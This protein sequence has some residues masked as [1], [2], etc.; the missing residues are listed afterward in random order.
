MKSQ[1][2]MSLFVKGTNDL[3]RK[4][5]HLHLIAFRHISGTDLERQLALFRHVCHRA[6]FV[7]D[8]EHPR[9]GN[10][11]TCPAKHLLL[12][13]RCIGKTYRDLH[14]EATARLGTLDVFLIILIPPD[15]ISFTRLTA[16]RIR[17]PSCDIWHIGKKTPVLL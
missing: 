14:L 13:F 1:R 15:L 3:R 8:K 5:F 16:I 7:S 6:L 11:H 17:P 9:R 4:A 12:S 2:K 10:I